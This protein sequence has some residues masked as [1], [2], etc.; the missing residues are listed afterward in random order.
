MTEAR[1]EL[2][3]PES[4]WQT[5]AVYLPRSRLTPETPQRIAEQIAASTN[6]SRM[7]YD[8]Y[9]ST[10]PLARVTV[11][12]RRPLAVTER[13]LARLTVEVD[14]RRGMV[15]QARGFRNRRA[16]GRVLTVLQT[17]AAR[18]NLRLAT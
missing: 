17:W 4:G 12:I 8:T 11:E 9:Q 18:E 14:P 5:L 7:T 16:A 15:V 1:L 2:R 6:A 13:E 3:S 10:S